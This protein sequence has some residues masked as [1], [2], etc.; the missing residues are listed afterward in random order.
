MKIFDGSQSGGFLD[1]D[2]LLSRVKTLE[3]RVD[4]LIAEY[5]ELL[6]RTAFQ[7]DKI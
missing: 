4:S 2:E 1:I 5:Q 6:K 7:N 3:Q